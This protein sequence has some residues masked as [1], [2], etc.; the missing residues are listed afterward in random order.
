[1][2][3]VVDHLADLT[4][5]R[6]RDLLDAALAGALR[7]LVDADA[8][9]VHRA[10]GDE[11]DMRWLNRAQVLRGA[12]APLSDPIYTELE[13]LPRLADRPLRAACLAQQSMQVDAGPP[14]TS[15]FALHG[16]RD[17]DGVLEIQT[18]TPLSAEAQRLVASVLRLYR[19]FESVLDYSER[20]TLTGLLNRKTFDESFYKSAAS[21]NAEPP[22]ALPAPAGD[23]RRRTAGPQV[24]FLGVIDIDHFKAVN[25]TWGHLIG[26]EVLL[27]MSRLMR[28]CFRYHDR[29]YRFG[30]EEFVVVLRCGSDADAAIAFNRL[31]ETVQA[32]VFPQV[33]QLTVSAG[34]TEIRMNDTPSAAFERADQAVYWAKTHGR[35]RV[36]GFAELVVSGELNDESKAG[37]VELF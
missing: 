21:L 17:V 14:V 20:D 37:G 22:S 30:G 8:V 2:S 18:A 26:D 23:K 10:V 7:E 1:M 24:P 4:A 33:G 13:S 6:D 34:Y 16:E 25:D 32:Y 15:C 19:N 28:G 5:L 35:N 36:C 9:G 3:Q 27:L 12:P 11:A 31:R 29:L